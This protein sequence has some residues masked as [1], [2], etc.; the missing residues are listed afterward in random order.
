MMAIFLKSVRSVNILLP[1]SSVIASPKGVAI[2]QELYMRLLRRKITA[3]QHLHLHDLP[4]KSS[5]GVTGILYIQK[6]PTGRPRV[7]CGRRA[8]GI[9]SDGCGLR[10]RNDTQ[11]RDFHLPQNYGSPQSIMIEI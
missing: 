3:S 4:S 1:N 8:D 7:F 5:A 6:P 9:L 10:K 11:D 2:S